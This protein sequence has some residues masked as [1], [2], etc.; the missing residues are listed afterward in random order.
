MLATKQN[1]KN[2]NFACI[3]ESPK[4]RMYRIS[5]VHVVVYKNVQE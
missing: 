4:V 2:A 1:V 5:Y 3:S